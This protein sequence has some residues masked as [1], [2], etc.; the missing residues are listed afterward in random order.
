VVTAVAATA[1]EGD[2]ESL[3]VRAWRRLTFGNIAPRCQGRL[4]G[5]RSRRGPVELDREVPGSAGTRE[6]PNC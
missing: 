2:S 5:W 4:A 1:G 3:R 6:K